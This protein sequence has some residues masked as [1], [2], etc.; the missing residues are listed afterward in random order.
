MK[1]RTVSLIVFLS[2]SS[3]LIVGRDTLGLPTAVASRAS[4]PSSYARFV[5]SWFHHGADLVVHSNGRGTYSYRTYVFCSNHVVT[6]CDKQT[7]NAI[8]AG[9]FSK[10]SLRR[11]AGNTAR[12]I[13]DNSAYSW[14]V[15]TTVTV[16]ARPNDTLVF[17]QA[18]TS[19]TIVCGPNAPAGFCGA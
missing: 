8:F 10:F 11:T 13:V 19:A 4:A 6:D 15:G 7:K 9:G 14:Q 1:R 17:Y 16:V 3:G 12:G 5:G 2:L 18:G